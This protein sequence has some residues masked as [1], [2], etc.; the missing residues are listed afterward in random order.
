MRCR[1][2]D[3]CASTGLLEAAALL[4][5][6]HRINC[7]PNCL[8]SACPAAFRAISQADKRF[9]LADWRARPLNEQMLAYARADTH[10]L[11]YCYDKLKARG[12]FVCMHS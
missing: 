9:Q 1:H 3:V 10:Y 5:Q 7:V 6:A 4:S 11:L 8:S 12:V 2:V